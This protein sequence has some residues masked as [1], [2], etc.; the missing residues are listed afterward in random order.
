MQIEVQRRLHEQLEVQRHLQLRIEAQ[1]KYLQG[2]LEKAQDTLGRQNV[3]TIGL[4]AAKVQLSDL[5]SKVSNQCLNSAFSGMKELSD[6]CL[7]QTQTTQPTDCSMDSCLT[8]C[9][10]SIRD[11]E[12]YN[13]PLGLKPIYY[14]ASTELRDGDNKTRLQKPELR[15]HEELKESRYLFSMANDNVEKAYAHPDVA[16]MRFKSYIYYDDWVEIFGKDRA[17]G[18]DAEDFVEIVEDLLKTNPVKNTNSKG[19]EP[20][21]DA[22]ND[23][24]LYSSPTVDLTTDFSDCPDYGEELPP[25]NMGFHTNGP[26]KA[27]LTKKVKIEK[28]KKEKQTRKRKTPDSYGSE[29]FKPDMEELMK[30]AKSTWADL[31]SKFAKEEDTYDDKAKKIIAALDSISSLT[32]ENRN[33]LSFKIMDNS[34]HISLFL[35]SSERNREMQAHMML[36]GKMP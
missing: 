24:M 32:D 4:E 29:Q 1:G 13:N 31:S 2:V 34:K 30:A 7:Q 9:E 36:D 16:N 8:S 21:N 35:N 5:V 10:G 20:V 3:G 19:K 12:L 11:Q 14:R 15:W 33:Y 18:D 27:K 22:S 17:T 28:I 23:D 25:Y 26:N 6:L